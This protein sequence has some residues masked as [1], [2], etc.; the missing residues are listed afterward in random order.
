MEVGVE[1]KGGHGL[2]Q[3]VPECVPPSP[4]AAKRL[5]Q[6]MHEVSRRAQHVTANKLKAGEA[7]KPHP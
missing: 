4:A 6:G 5:E 2:L 1:L 3:S 7:A